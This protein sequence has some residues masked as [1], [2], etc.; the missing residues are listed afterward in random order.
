MTCS[1]YGTSGALATACPPLVLDVTAEGA[2]GSELAE[3]V[4]DHCLRHEHRHVLAT[5]VHGDGV[6]EHCRHDHRAARPRLDDVLGA[7]VVLS[8]HLLDQVVVDEGTLLQTP[9]HLLCLLA[10]LRGLAA[11]H[12]HAVAVLVGAAGAAFGLAPRAD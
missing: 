12:D 11:T 7:L 1:A 10:P 3:L 4:P 9:W 5:V 6:T 8:V 2:R